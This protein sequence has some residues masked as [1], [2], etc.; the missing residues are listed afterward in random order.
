MDRTI[1]QTVGLSR[2]QR[3]LGFWNSIAPTLGLFFLAPLT[4]EYLIGYS[5]ET[6]T[7]MLVGLWLLAPLYGGAAII[8]RESARRTGR[9]WP[10]IILLS[11]AFGVFQAGLIDHSLFDPSYQ[12]TDSWYNMPVLSKFFTSTTNFING[13]QFLHN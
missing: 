6:F 7:E 1:S 3:G 10:T 9:G 11:L 4:A 13:I 5:S 8:I 2:S 12:I